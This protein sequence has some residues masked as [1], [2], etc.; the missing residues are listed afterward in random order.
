M[1]A[2]STLAVCCLALL[3]ASLAVPRRAAAADDV[4]TNAAESLAACHA[5]AGGQLG[6]YHRCLIEEYDRVSGLTDALTDKLLDTIGGH[7]PFG[8]LRII[9]WSSAV[10]Q[11]Q[12]AWRKFVEWDCEWGGHMAL[13]TPGAAA[14]MTE[15]RIDRAFQ[16]RQQLTERFEAVTALIA[17]AQKE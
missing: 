4:P 9:Q 13:G 11:S 8:R 6:L 3:L 1:R 10:Q 17:S 12:S 5:Q 7:R 2:A 14:A 16:R 15:C